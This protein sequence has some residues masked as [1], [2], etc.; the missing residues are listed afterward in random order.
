M[1]F[2]EFR[3]VDDQIVTD[4]YGNVTPCIH[5]YYTLGSPALLWSD[6]YCTN[7]AIGYLNVGTDLDVGNDITVGNDVAV[8]GDIDVTNDVYIGG[9]LNVDEWTYVIGDITSENDINS[10][11]NL[12]CVNDL[13]VTDCAEIGDDLTVTDDINF[14]SLLNQTTSNF[15]VR[16]NGT[17]RPAQLADIDAENDSIY[18]STTQGKLVYKDAGGVVHDLY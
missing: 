2:G 5:N 4:C 14:S 9:H 7:G 1:P 10:G 8:A 11:N 12:N 15:L 17:I 18:Y 3:V 6:L 13:D 16:D